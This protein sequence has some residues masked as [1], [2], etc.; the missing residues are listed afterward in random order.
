MINIT[1]KPNTYELEITGHAGHD[2]KGKDIV[3]AAV[4]T[5]FYTLGQALFESGVLFKD[6]LVFKD[7]DG[8]GYIK[9]YTNRYNEDD[10]NAIFWT[11][12]TGFEMLAN[13][14]PENFSFNVEIEG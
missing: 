9:G 1:F 10:V 11:I 8:H 14:Y 12:L 5:L 6:E 13:Q 3:C 4:S 7:E 2:V